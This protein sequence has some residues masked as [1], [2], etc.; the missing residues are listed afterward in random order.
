MEFKKYSLNIVRHHHKKL[1]ILDDKH[2]NTKISYINHNEYK[3]VDL[4]D[5]FPI[6]YNQGTIGSCTAN[7]LCGIIEYIIPDFL[8]SRLF[9]YYNERLIEKDVEHDCGA[10][11]FDGIQSLQTF[12][13]CSELDWP[14]D[15]NKFTIK[16]LEECYNKALDHKVLQV[17]NIHNDITMMKNALINGIPFVVGIMIYSS[18]E[19]DYVAKT[20]NVSMPR[21]YEQ[22]LGGH[23]ILICGFDDYKK[24]WIARNSWGPEWGDKGY[25]Y[26][27]Y[28]Y[29][30]DS[31]LSTDLWC[32]L[33]IL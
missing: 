2:F 3:H 8:P 19:S 17:K 6:V 30:L 12:G 27:P 11:L 32:I 20:G 29:L 4:R 23:A 21:Y 10:T 7:A 18:F 26:L 24:V 33:K 14:Y 13:I 25:F 9:L 22:C 5:K 28:L 31:T 1:D 15:I 16:P